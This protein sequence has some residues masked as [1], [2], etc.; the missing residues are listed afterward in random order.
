M[1]AELHAH[2]LPSDTTLADDTR[3]VL[4]SASL[5][6]SKHHVAISV[7]SVGALLLLIN[8]QIMRRE[9]THI[10]F[11]IDVYPDGSLGEGSWM[12]ED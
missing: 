1:S 7:M 8:R 11:A 5:F 4:R 10:H 3:S 9:L 6:Y 2:P 12:G